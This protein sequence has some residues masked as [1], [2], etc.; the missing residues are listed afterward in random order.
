MIVLGHVF[1][2]EPG[3]EWLAEWL[4]PK[5]PG[6]PVLHIPSGEPFIWA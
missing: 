1:S 2:E 3:M 6:I 5:L 4:Q